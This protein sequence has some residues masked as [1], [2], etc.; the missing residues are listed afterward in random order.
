METLEAIEKR[1]SVRDYLNKKVE[2][3]KIVTILNAATQAPSGMNRQPWHFLVLTETESRKKVMSAN[4]AYNKW[5][6]NAPAV[7]IA[8]ADSNA[9]Y[10][11]E[12][13]KIYLLDMG[14]ALENLLIAATDLGLGACITIGFSADKLKKELGIPER[15]TPIVV[16]P[17]GYESK[18]K[19]A[20][21]L[22][23][24]VTLSINKKKGFEDVVSFEK[25]G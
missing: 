6:N 8:L 2:N 16:I 15:Y 13:Q 19:V 14:L 24:G 1:H 18:E 17:I 21:A 3:E 23:A 12:E 4:A 11:R 20:G 9:F 22:I 10:G 5:M 25:I 7:I